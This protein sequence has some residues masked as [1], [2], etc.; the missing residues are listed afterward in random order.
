M[1]LLTWHGTILRVEQS[2]NRLIHAPLVPARPLAQDFAFP[3]PPDADAASIALPG[4]MQ[5]HFGP[6]P[7]RSARPRLGAGHITRGD[8][9]LS[10]SPDSPYPTF[11]DAR[12]AAESS[13]L[14]LT[15][16][17]VAALRALLAAPHRHVES[18][19]NVPP[20]SLE[21]GFILTAGADN[22]LDL[23]E[24]CPTPAGDCVLL[25]AG[26]GTLIALAAPTTAAELPLLAAAPPPA[27]ADP[28]AFDAAA[29]ACLTL[30]GA[31]EYRFLPIAASMSTRDWFY[32][33]ATTPPLT[34]RHSARNILLRAE[35]AFLLTLTPG[36]STILTR[37]GV[38]HAPPLPDA[39][40][41]YPPGVSRE[42]D[43]F[44]I[45]ASSLAEA[46]VLTGPHALLPAAA[47][48]TLLETLLPLVLM[49]PHLPA[50]T[51]LLLPDSQPPE[52][53]PLADLLTLFGLAHFRIQA[54]PAALCRAQSLIWPDHCAPPQVSADTLRAARSRAHAVQPPPEARR[55]IFLT[56]G[57][58][59]PVRC[60]TIA[61]N[62]GYRLV[63]KVPADQAARAALFAGASAIIAVHGRLL[64]NLLFCQAG[65]QV[66]ELTPL[67]AWRPRYA[68][69]SD[70]LGLTHAVLPCAVERDTLAPDTAD[71]GRL[72]RIMRARR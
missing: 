46:P 29:T 35:D 31:P 72:L 54:V 49:A 17:E 67:T 45:T 38:L 15:E 19:R 63:D 37:E 59:D 44:F 40:P 7:S 11:S 3:A 13:V 34:G 24:A 57:I 23:A 25:P 9:T 60:A 53:S 68:R 51:T 21:P 62:L 32:T 64:D 28:A 4:G 10:V 65:T 22:R 47:Q 69:L 18:G 71:F 70:Q 1:L 43:T 61:A 6:R 55:R 27:A 26:A 41:P 5:L 48:S 2:Q 20:F 52:P 12:P 30:Q 39:R 58:A 50:D 8:K 42:A 36:R 14:P 66:I 33:A 16:A 56:G